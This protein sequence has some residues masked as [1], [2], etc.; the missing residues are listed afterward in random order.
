MFNVNDKV[1][2]VGTGVTGVVV[3]IDSGSDKPYIVR[4]DDEEGQT[5]LWWCDEYEIRKQ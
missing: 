3:E 2:E 4:F 5:G 1:V